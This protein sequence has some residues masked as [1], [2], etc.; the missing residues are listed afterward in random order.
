ML[1]CLYW[2]V[3]KCNYEINMDNSTKYRIRNGTSGIIIS[4]EYYSKK[5]DL[6]TYAIVIEYTFTLVSQQS[7][8]K[9]GGNH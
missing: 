7:K 1:T 4:K 2:T 3:S 6:L 8:M 5:L 9:R